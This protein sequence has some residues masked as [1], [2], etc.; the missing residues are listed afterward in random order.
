MIDTRVTIPGGLE[1]G[2]VRHRE[3]RIRPIDGTDLDALR[4]T[5]GAFP[6]ERISALL[7]RCVTGLGPWEAPAER[8]EGLSVGDRDA[9]ALA[10]RRA[11]LGDRIDCVLDCPECGEAMDIELSASELLLSPYEHELVAS[12]HGLRVRA[13]TAGEL[14]DAARTGARDMA[15]GSRRLLAACI[16][17]GGVAGDL[18]DDAEAAIAMAM[19]ELDP[20][21]DLQI[22]MACPQCGASLL[23][24]FDPA[25]CF[26]QE[27]DDRAETLYR[28]VH[29]LALGYHWSEREILELPAPKR[30][31]Y[32]DLLDEAAEAVVP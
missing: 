14:E 11:T 3:A 21:A 16:V 9:L 30:R 29:A 5:A 27:L 12:V 26:L 8:L 15:A 10:L 17:G 25:G 2:G 18:A 28:E 7:A 6:A 22:A 31:M 24:P 4:S 1:E 20:Q 13:P 19:A 32:L 23:V